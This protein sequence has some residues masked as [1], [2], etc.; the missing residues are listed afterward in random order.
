MPTV[1]GESVNS[2]SDCLRIFQRHG[3]AVRETYRARYLFDQRSRDPYKGT[4]LERPP[5][6]IESPSDVVYPW[7]QI[8]VAAA[9][10]AGSDYP[11]LAAHHGITLDRVDFIVEG[12]FDPRGEFDGLN[13]FQAPLDSASCYLSLHLR[14]TLVA[15]APR[16]ELE[17]IHQR[18]VLKNMVLGALRGIPKTDELVILRPEMVPTATTC[19]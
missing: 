18:V 5:S 2:V 9:N 15:N 8:F 19:L 11:M 17:A 10:C 4:T 16:E 3:D 1:F 12:V 7:E 14:A 13:G 6:L